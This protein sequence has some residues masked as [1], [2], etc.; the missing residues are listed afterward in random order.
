MMRDNI[1]FVAA[2]SRG[3]DHYRL[4]EDLD[5]LRRE[6]TKERTEGFQKFLEA[7]IVRDIINLHKRV[8]TFNT[9][10]KKSINTTNKKAKRI[11][12]E[13]H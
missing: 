2:V 13:A 11:V 7:Y 8:L 1:C 12:K 4:Y 10:K 5:Y 9:G 3:V 6:Y